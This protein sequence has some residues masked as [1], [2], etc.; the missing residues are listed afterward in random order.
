MKNDKE[1]YY[2]YELYVDNEDQG[3]G[4]LHGLS[5][6][7]LDEDYEDSLLNLFNDLPIPM[8]YMGN[9]KKTKAYFSKYGKETFKKAIQTIID[10]YEESGFFRIV[11][12]IKEINKNDIL[13]ED[14]YQIIIEDKEPLV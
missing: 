5:E 11:E 10:I 6:L 9:Q 8:F 1:I 12:E 7:E 3:V 2:R 14:E 4:F 13:Y